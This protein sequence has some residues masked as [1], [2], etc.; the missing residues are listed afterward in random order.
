MKVFESLSIDGDLGLHVHD[1]TGASDNVFSVCDLNGG[2]DGSCKPF[3]NRG[4]SRRF[5]FGSWPSGN[6]MDF[7]GAQM[8]QS[9]SFEAQEEPN[10]IKSAWLNMPRKPSPSPSTRI[11]RQ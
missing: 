6:K 3:W 10:L 7:F 5:R 9:L 1:Y 4:L 8:E 11:T 2:Y